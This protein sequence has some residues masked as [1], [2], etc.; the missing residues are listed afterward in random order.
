MKQK[1]EAAGEGVLAG[2]LDYWTQAD[3]LECSCFAD[4]LEKRKRLPG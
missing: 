2:D 3:Y 1:I 4:V